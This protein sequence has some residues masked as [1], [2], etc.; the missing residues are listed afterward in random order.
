MAAIV[1]NRFVALDLADGWI[2][3]TR[4]RLWMLS[5]VDGT[6]SLRLTMFPVANGVRMNL[7]TLRAL[8]HERHLANA[9][10]RRKVGRS[11]V[12]GPAGRFF[13]DEASWTEGPIFCVASTHRVDFRAL[14]LSVRCIERVWTVSDGKYVL[15]A[16]LQTDTQDAFEP[17]AAACEG[18]M[19]SVRF[20]G[21]S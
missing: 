14:Q 8:E 20:E 9:E 2:E 3:R 5:A 19:H 15:E 4:V 16:T 18:M 12:G 1:R 6:A 21:P 10:Y 11:R 13:V 7:A 17:A